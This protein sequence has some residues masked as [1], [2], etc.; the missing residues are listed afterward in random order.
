LLS[1][2]GGF[3]IVMMTGAYLKAAALNMIIVVDGFISTAALL[4]AQAID[5]D[6]L[7]NC[8]FAHTSGEKGHEKML[9][10]MG[11]KPLL[12]LGMRLGEGTGAALAIPFIQSAVN[13]LNEMASFETAGVSNR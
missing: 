13:F 9:A 12:N 11:A 1:C 10:Y 4:A 3:E 7:N 2:I 5:K 8:I 6:I